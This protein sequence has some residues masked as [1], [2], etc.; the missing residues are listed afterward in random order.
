[1]LRGGE[2][3]I[4]LVVYINGLYGVCTACVDAHV[5]AVSMFRL[6]MNTEST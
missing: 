1:M 2:Y 5:R 6:S 3:S 4:P